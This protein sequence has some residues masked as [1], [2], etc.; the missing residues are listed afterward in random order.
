MDDTRALVLGG[1]GITGIAWET[2][3]LW[4]LLEA[5]VDVSA[6][7]RV[8]GTSAG[9]VVGAQLTSGTSIEA[10]YEFQVRPPAPSRPASMGRGV[11]A[12]YAAAMLASAG[13]LER[14][15]RRMGGQAQKVARAGRTPSLAERFAAI[16]ERL[17][18]LTWPDRD[19][20]VTAVDADSGTRRAFGRSDGVPLREAVTASCAV[21]CVYP[22]V[23]IA[24]RTWIDG[25]VHS[26]TNADLATGHDRVLVLAPMD[27]SVGPLRNATQLLDGLDLAS[28][29][30]TP[31]AASREAIG[32]NVLD[33][34][35]RPASARAGRAQAADLAVVIGDLW[36]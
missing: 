11:A 32:A 21:P 22:P 33:P 15:G 4:G 12:R 5:G 28:L 34:A 6:A 13:D 17:P 27:R 35:S 7:D 19:L 25:G 24:G 20:L 16:E 18:V 2:G 26:G 1:G 14:F 36:D 31:D 30:V 23:P 8:I 29:V 10:L 9:S 3:L